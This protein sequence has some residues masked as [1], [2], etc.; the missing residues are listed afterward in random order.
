MKEIR[1]IFDKKENTL[2]FHNFIFL[3]KFYSKENLKKLRT[4]LS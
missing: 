3:D 1:E 2:L 4:Y